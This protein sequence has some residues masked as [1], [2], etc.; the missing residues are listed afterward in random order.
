MKIYGPKDRFKVSIEGQGLSFTL[1]PLTAKQKGEVM[2]LAGLRGG[3]QVQD[4]WDMV[5]LA[6]RYGVKAWDGF[7]DGEDKP[8]PLELD[9]DGNLTEGALDLL[10]NLPASP[11][12]VAIASAL[13]VAVGSKVDAVLDSETGQPIEGVSIVHAGK[14]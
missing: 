4:R 3:N 14:V 6:L 5:K 10:L 9:A 12:G 7:T 11:Q 13:Q 2:A 1:A 8:L